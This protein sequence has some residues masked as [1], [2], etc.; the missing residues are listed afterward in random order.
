MSA[1]DAALDQVA[2]R[3]PGAVAPIPQSAPQPQSGGA[4]LPPEGQ[5]GGALHLNVPNRGRAALDM[6][7]G[8]MWQQESGNRQTDD[9]GRIITSPKGAMGVSQLTPDTAKQLGVDPTDEAQNRAGGKMYLGQL[10]D[11]Y[12]NWDDTL[13]AYNAG[14]GRVDKW[15]AEGRPEDGKY[16]LPAETKN[17]VPAVLAHAGLGDT[18]PTSIVEAKRVG[19]TDDIDKFL[20]PPTASGEDASE[21][22]RGG[23]QDD[24]ADVEA[25]S[26]GH[27]PN[28]PPDERISALAHGVRQGMQELVTG[29]IQ[30]TLEQVSPQTAQKFTNMVNSFEDQFDA[31]KK[32]PYIA[33]A[34]KTVGTALGIMAGGE[35]LGAIKAPQAIA[36][37]MPAVS[38]RLGLTA[39][40]ALAGGAAGATSYNPKPE[41]ASRLL[42]GIVGAAFGGT[43]GQITR[44]V[45]IGASRIADNNAY[46][47][48]IG[49]VKDAVGTISPSASQIKQRFL[50]HYDKLWQEKDAKYTLRN[51]AGREIG[52]GFP[53]EAMGTPVKDAMD[54]T[55][56]AGVAPTPATRSVAARVDEELGGPAARAMEKQHQAAIKQHEKDYKE[57]EK[58]YTKGMES[59]PAELRAAQLRNDIA[60]GRI[61]P[62]PIHPG[63]FEPPAIT[64][65]QYSSAVQAINR[66]KS[67]TRDPATRHQLLEMRGNLESA[68]KEA[69]AEAGMS[70]ERF[71]KRSRE[72]ATFNARN[73]APIQRQFHGMNPSQIRGDPN[74]PFSGVTPAKFFD[75]ATTLMEGHDM[76][77]LRSFMQ[78]VGPAAKEDMLK[79]FAYKMLN[80]IERGKNPYEKFSAYIKDHTD[81]IREVGGQELLE[82]V[83][84]IAK[85][86][87]RLAVEPSK[88][89]RL[90]DILTHHSWLQAFGAIKV[91]E[92]VMTGEP[93]HIFGGLGMIAA[94]YA[95]HLL[96][97]VITKLQEVPGTLPLIRQIGKLQPDS[98]QMEAAMKELERRVVVSAAV[99]GRRAA[100]ATAPLAPVGQ[101]IGNAAMSLTGLQ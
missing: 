28:D 9:K 29:P 31:P 37:I 32:H 60:S 99:L 30:A 1:L 62:A 80:E 92:G 5:Y 81:A 54:G 63:E 6:I 4:P 69:A 35:L 50:E 55:R 79:A 83:Q 70:V 85:I 44:A 22:G 87:N 84:G 95:G 20:K 7:A 67:R 33:F 59:L 40:A 49:T 10:F 16:A 101:A 93:R 14:P 3:T 36:S 98:K 21:R 74:V 72:A 18:S 17:Y 39:R 46:R 11:K 66:E 77:A 12:G 45:G 24:L 68:A 96:F 48:F 51:A 58:T 56:V 71:I 91:A 52:D 53:R 97:N 26:M 88:R 100:P 76:D 19:Q 25:I 94:P 89:S 15:I 47:D 86:A 42:E 78:M 90:F 43:V 57:W 38:A 82:R 13:A 65:A 64:P 75:Q 23:P 2:A 73:I 41:E 27:A 8:A 34:G 61:P